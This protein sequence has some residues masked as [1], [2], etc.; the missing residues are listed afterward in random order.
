MI[1]KYSNGLI[2]A[3]LESCAPTNHVALAGNVF[4][5]IEEVD[6]KGNGHKMSQDNPTGQI[7]NGMSKL[8]NKYV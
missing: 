5:M 8:L 3:I 4:I 6:K 7:E 2:C 1:N